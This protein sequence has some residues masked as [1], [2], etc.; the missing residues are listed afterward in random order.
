LLLFRIDSSRDRR[1]KQETGD[2]HCFNFSD[3]HTKLGWRIKP[4][5]SITVGTSIRL[6]PTRAQVTP[7]STTRHVPAASCV[8]ISLSYEVIASPWIDRWIPFSFEGRGWALAQEEYCNIAKQ[9]WFTYCNSKWKVTDWCI[10]KYSRDRRY[11][12][13][14]RIWYMLYRNL[15]FL[16]IFSFVFCPNIPVIGNI[17]YE[18]CFWYSWILTCSYTAF[19][20]LESWPAHI[21]FTG[22]FSLII[23]SSEKCRYSFLIV[24]L[25]WK[26]EKSIPILV[27]LAR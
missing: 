8:L 23:F 5:C 17:I 6:H 26:N 14:K 16:R 9:C 10:T 3:H 7:S 27:L 15:L 18:T 11:N 1:A 2:D 12:H 20:T 19:S 25:L 22:V 24:T 13:C 4:P 21:L